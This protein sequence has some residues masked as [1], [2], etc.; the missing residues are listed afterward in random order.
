MVGG[1]EL[2]VLTD[3]KAEGEVQYH[4]LLLF[5]A[6]KLAARMTPPAITNAPVAM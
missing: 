1:G 5:C 4:F 3:L 2:D 6:A